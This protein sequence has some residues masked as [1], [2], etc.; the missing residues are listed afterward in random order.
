M[1]WLLGGGIFFLSS[2]SSLS[3]SF[4][5]SMLIQET[6]AHFRPL[7]LTKRYFRTMLAPI[8]RPLRLIPVFQDGLV[9]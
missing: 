7:C 8:S 3:F 4:F 5:L 9:V 1:T 2:L 6:I